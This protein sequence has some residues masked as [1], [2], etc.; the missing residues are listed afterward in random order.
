MFTFNVCMMI[1]LFIIAKNQFNETLD[2]P[3]FH[4]LCFLMI[5]NEINDELVSN[6]IINKKNDA[7][8]A[9]TGA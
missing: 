1:V 7:I 5:M 6:Y 2:Q 8:M 9:V 3:A 4:K